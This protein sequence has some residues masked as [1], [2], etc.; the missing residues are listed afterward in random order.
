MTIH[1]P[2]RKVLQFPA[3][4]NTVPSSLIL[5]TLTMEAILSS[6]LSVLTRATWH[7]IPENGIF[8]TLFD[9]KRQ[10]QSLF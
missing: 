9:L 5:F 7:H 3:S 1:G 2:I 8:K 4:A 10:Y 6:K